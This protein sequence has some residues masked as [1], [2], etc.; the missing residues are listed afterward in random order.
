[1]FGIFADEAARDRALGNL[2]CEAGWRVFLC[3]TLS[4]SDYCQA[5]STGA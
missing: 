4:R 5:I 1:V 3:H 2:R